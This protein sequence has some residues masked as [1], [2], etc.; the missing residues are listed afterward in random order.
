[1]I[2]LNLACGTHASLDQRVRNIDWNIYA[3]LRSRKLLWPLAAVLMNG[4]RYEKFKALPDN[5]VL[6]DL[7][8]GIPSADNSVDVVY[9]SHYL[10]HI[11][12]EYVPAL[13]REVHRVLKPGGIHRIVVPDLE[14]LGREYVRS[15]DACAR[16]Q[17]QVASHDARVAE[18][19]RWTVLREAPGSGQQPRL[20]RWLENRLLGDARARGQ[21]HQW[22]YDQYNLEALLEECGFT[23]CRKLAWN[24]SEVPDWNLTRLDEN[25]H[26]TEYRPGSLYLEARRPL[27]P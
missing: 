2:I 21:T 3:R 20:R 10:E 25:G 18:L 6:W 11:D 5:V 4:S 1:M 23:A 15:L 7:R 13:L 17:A 19:Y 22:M 27:Q 14:I 12:R 26:G 9:H 24:S 16:Q 8:R